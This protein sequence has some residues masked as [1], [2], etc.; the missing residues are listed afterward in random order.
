[1]PIYMCTFYITL[2]ATFVTSFF[3]VVIFIPIF[4]SVQ[5]NFFLFFC[6]VFSCIVMLEFPQWWSIKCYLILRKNEEKSVIAVEGCENLGE[7]WKLVVELYGESMAG[8]R[9][10]TGHCL[11]YRPCRFLL[12]WPSMKLNYSR[13]MVIIVTC[14]TE[15]FFLLEMS[16]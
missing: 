10:F 13:K 1:M 5:F 2:Y 14:Q 4:I 6:H 7:K 8:M 15:Q 16:F 12:H 11:C 3:N 9:F